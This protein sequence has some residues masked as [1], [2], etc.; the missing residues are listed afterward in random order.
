MP[1]SRSTSTTANYVEK[2]YTAEELKWE[3]S[4]MRH[5]RESF[6]NP[7]DDDL[8]T[9]FPQVE[10]RNK[11]EFWAKTICSARKKM[12][13]GHLTWEQEP[14]ERIQSEMDQRDAEATSQIR[15]R[16]ERIGLSNFFHIA[17]DGSDL[18]GLY[19]ERHTLRSAEAKREQQQDQQQ[20]VAQ[21]VRIGHHPR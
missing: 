6:V 18:V 2:N 7:Q 17:V 20:Q 10:N 21:R 8:S 11:K 16:L 1:A 5:E 3:Y 19:S 4:R 15:D 12:I 13:E 9:V 14:R